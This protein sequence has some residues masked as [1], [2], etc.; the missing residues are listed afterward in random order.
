MEKWTASLN[1]DAAPRLRIEKICPSKSLFLTLLKKNT[2]KSSVLSYV[3]TY[4]WMLHAMT[5]SVCLF[6]SHNLVN[7]KYNQMEDTHYY[8][9]NHAPFLV[10]DTSLTFIKWLW[11]DLSPGPYVLPH[12]A[13]NKPKCLKLIENISCQKNLPIHKLW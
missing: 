5:K 1:L 2:W 8:P 3:T 11:L 12:S 9:T 4:S 10:C 7:L 13:I 6:L